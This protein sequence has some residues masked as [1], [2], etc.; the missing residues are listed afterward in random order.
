M[1]ERDDVGA[2]VAA[3]IE[4][5]DRAIAEMAEKKKKYLDEPSSLG[6]QI[7]HWRDGSWHLIES[8][9]AWLRFTGWQK[10]WNPLPN[11]G[12]G[13]HYFVVC[14]HEAGRFFNILPHRYLVDDVGRIVHEHY[15]SVLSPDEIERFKALNERYYESPQTHPL[16]ETENKDFEA[17]RDRL[18]RSWLAPAA[19]MRELLRV[20]PALPQEGDAAW[21]VLAASGVVLSSGRA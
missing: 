13:E 18:W 5:M 4:D 15:F 20:I 19:A 12:S 7:F 3:S 1:T 10:P 2:Q 8:W 21:R 14:V 11:V 9:D 16:S 6:Q 17:I